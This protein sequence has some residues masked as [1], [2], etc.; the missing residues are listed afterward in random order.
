L[1]RKRKGFLEWWIDRLNT[2]SSISP[3]PN[4]SFDYV[5]KVFPRAEEYLY[6]QGPWTAIKLAIIAYYQDVYTII[7]REH[8]GKICYVDAFAGPGL[9]KIKEY[10]KLLYGSPILAILV[11]RQNKKFDKLFFI[12]LDSNK[13]RILRGIVDYLTQNGFINK[14]QVS[15]ICQDMN[16]INYNSLLKECDHSLV[17]L[18]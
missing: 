13:A 1:G 3:S 2:L 10:D 4:V 9:V 7:A 8:F 12:E 14:N 17:F 5:K 6:L 15:I 11:P 18:E 16:S